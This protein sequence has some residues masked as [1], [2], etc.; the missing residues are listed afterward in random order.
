MLLRL[1]VHIRR[2]DSDERRTAIADFLAFLVV[3]FAEGLS[4]QL[5]VPFR[6]GLEIVAIRHHDFDVAAMLLRSSEFQ[7][8]VKHCRVLPDIIVLAGFVHVLSTIEEALDIKADAGSQRQTDFAENRETSANAVRNSILRPAFF[9]GQL[10]EERLVLHV[11]VRDSDDFDI[12][13]RELLQSIID[14]HEVRHRIERAAGFRDDEQQNLEIAFL[15]ILQDF[16]LILEM[17]DEV[18]RAARVNVVA[19]EIN[20][21]EAVALFL[22]QLIPVSTA[23][24]I[25]QD[26]IAEIRT[27][28]TH[29]N[30]NVNIVLDMVREFLQMFER[31]RAVEM[32][33]LYIRQ[34]GEQNFF[35]LAVFREMR[36]DEARLAHDLHGLMCLLEVFLI[37]LEVCFRDFALTIK[38]VIVERKTGF[39]FQT[40]VLT[41]LCLF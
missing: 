14:H 5:D 31:A 20:F 1:G 8:C 4:E 30:D 19:A 11:R 21:R 12:D 15:M 9:D 16:G 34:L 36:T 33:F 41:L 25:E 32:A 29:G 23:L 18:A 28:D 2:A 6:N 22:R 37:G 27:A 40:H 26:L 3:L 10:L 38:V 24:Y 17:M 13:A 39:Q 7:G 35:R